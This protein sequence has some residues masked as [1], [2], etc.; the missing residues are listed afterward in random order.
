MDN[1]SFSAA[2]YAGAGDYR[3]A[4]WFSQKYSALRQEILSEEKNR[5]LADKRRWY[6]TQKHENEIKLLE[7][8]NKLKNLQRS[9][10]AAGLGLL[11]IIALLAYS[12]QRNN[13][14]RERQLAEVRQALLQK[15]LEHEAL[16]KATLNQKIAFKN[17]ELTNFALDHSQK[18]EL[19]RSL[20]T[21]LTHIAPEVSAATASRLRGL[22]Q[23][24]R[25]GLEINREAEEFHLH[26]ET[27]YKDFFFQLEEQFPGLTQNEKRLCGQVRL[28]LS[29]KDVASLNNISV[30][31]IEMA[32]YRLRKRLQ[33]ST[34]DD[35]T[36]FLRKL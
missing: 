24:L 6:E 5:K 15:E 36:E 29:I 3:Q 13:R 19:L 33:L 10:L 2:M 26:V 11:A 28:G 25:Q 34:E 8:E 31:S 16:E 20:E 18:N 14:R 12:Q 22:I 35:L 4:Y 32:R 1:Y 21:D 17:R 23:Q 27:E 7:Q 9:A 30:K